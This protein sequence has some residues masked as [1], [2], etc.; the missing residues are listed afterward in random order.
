MKNTKKLKQK[1]ETKKCHSCSSTRETNSRY[2]LSCWIEDCVRKTL[3]VTEKQEKKRIANLL[4]QKLKNQNFT[5]CYTARPLIT[6]INLSLDHILPSSI[7]PEGLADLDNL[8]W[9]DLS[10]NV[11]KSNLLPKNFLELCEA[12]VRTRSTLLIK[13]Y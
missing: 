11:A 13:D 1:N 9:V 6:G 4:H 2:C 8:V 7:F 5:C 3:K 10:C 12:V